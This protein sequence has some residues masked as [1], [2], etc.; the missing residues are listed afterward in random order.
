MLKIINTCAV[1]F[2]SW[3]PCYVCVSRRWCLKHASCCRGAGRAAAAYF[4]DEVAEAQ[5]RYDKC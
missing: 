2:H 3:Y 4:T 1:V 5:T